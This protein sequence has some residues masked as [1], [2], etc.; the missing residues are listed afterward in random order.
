MGAMDHELKK[1]VPYYGTMKRAGAFRQ[2]PEAPE[3]T[4]KND[5]DRI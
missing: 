5:T 2:P 1:T 4:E 3:A